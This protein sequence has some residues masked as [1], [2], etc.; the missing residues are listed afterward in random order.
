[1]KDSWLM[2]EGNWCNANTH[3]FDVLLITDSAQGII[4]IEAL[5]SVV[6]L[7]MTIDY[8]MYVLYIDS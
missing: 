6:H 8:I 3:A 7:L 5:V 2:E 4:G 1:M